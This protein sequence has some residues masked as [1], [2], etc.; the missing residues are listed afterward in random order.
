MKRKI[1]LFVCGLLLTTLLTPSFAFAEREGG[2]S[3]RS[4]DADHGQRVRRG[5]TAGGSGGA[6]G[7]ATG[8]S[9][10]SVCAK[11]HNDGRTGTPP[12]GHPKI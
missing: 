10:T 5:G 6:T 4:G 11:C 8:G 7:G 3:G 2:R 12:S 9:T 1:A